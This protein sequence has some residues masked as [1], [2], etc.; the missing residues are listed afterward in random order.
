MRS[1]N[2]I[3]YKE[4]VSFLVIVAVTMRLSRLEYDSMYLGISVPTIR[5]ILP[6]QKQCISTTLHDVIPQK[7]VTLNKFFNLHS[8]IADCMKIRKVHVRH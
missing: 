6:L 2:E 5:K 8:G 4:V 3:N 7:T 1:V